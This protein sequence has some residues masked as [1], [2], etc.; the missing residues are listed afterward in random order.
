MD[1]GAAGGGDPTP[2]APPRRG[3]RRAPRR[4]AR[5]AAVRRRHTGRATRPGRGP[6]ARAARRVRRPDAADRGRR[7]RRSPG[8]HQAI[9]V[10]MGVRGAFGV[11]QVLHMLFDFDDLAA[12]PAARMGGH[13]ALRVED[14][15]QALAGH[16]AQGALHLGGRHRVVVEVEAHVGG[17]AH[18]D[19]LDLFADKRRRGQAQ[20]MVAL[21]LEGL[22]HAQGG[23]LRA[24]AFARVCH[25][26]GGGLGVEVVQVGELAP[27][28]EGVA[29]IA[30][31]ALDPPLLVAAS[32]RHRARLVAVMPGQGQKRGVQADG[33]PAALEH[34]R[35]QVVVQGDPGGAAPGF[36]GGDVA[37]QEALHARVEEETQEDLARPRQHHDEAH[38]GAARA[39]DLQMPEV[40]PVDLG[41]LPCNVRRRR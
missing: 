7:A 6:C 23:V 14:A 8:A 24:G 4:R 27:G 40:R 34:G 25:A 15:H 19:R 20:Q 41:L 17:L 10:A 39:A 37:E 12:V 36:E 22:A 3:E 33:I 9:G 28:E 2:G 38:E 1:R 26:P 29:D 32:W 18:A 11:D 13:D 21:A 31:A 30:D 35:L 5:R 16:H